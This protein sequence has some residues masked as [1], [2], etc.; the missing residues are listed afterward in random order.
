MTKKELFDIRKTAIWKYQY[1][2]RA[3][4]IKRNA[5][6]EVYKKFK[7]K[8]TT[9]QMQTIDKLQAKGWFDI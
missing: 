9:V 4:F 8:S 5:T 2:P 3:A 7:K 6:P 1:G